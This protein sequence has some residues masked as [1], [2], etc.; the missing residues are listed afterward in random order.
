MN[1]QISK[2][3]SQKTVVITSIVTLIFG[4]AQIIFPSYVIDI[5]GFLAGFG[6]LTIGLVSVLIYIKNKD[7]T[8][9]GLAKGIILAVAGAYFI[10][11]SSAPLQIL[12][13]LLGLFIVLNG[14]LGLQFSLDAK[15]IGSEKWKISLIFSIVN[16]VL[17]LIILFFPFSTLEVLIVYNGIFMLVSAVLNLLSLI[18]NKTK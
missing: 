17:G 13:L 5:I 9:N 18:F 1:T 2:K 8:S 16:M 11:N 6:L 4:L 3:M 12:S 14:V 10:F 7:N 15:K